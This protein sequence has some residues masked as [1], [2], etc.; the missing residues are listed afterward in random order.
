MAEVYKNGARG[1]LNAGIAAGDL[2]LTLRS[3]QGVLFPAWAGV[4]YSWGLLEQG[5][6]SN[7]TKREFVQFTNRSTDLLT[8]VRAQQGSSALAFDKGAR[9]SLPLTAQTRSDLLQSLGF[10]RRL[11]VGAIQPE[12]AATGDG[13]G[14]ISSAF[15]ASAFTRPTPSLGGGV[16]P[17]MP[18]LVGARFVANTATPAQ[19]ILGTAGAAP[20]KGGMEF[21][22]RGPL[23]ED[24]SATRKVIGVSN[25]SS[26][27]LISTV[28]PST[29]SS[30]AMVAFG[31]DDTIAIGGNWQVFTCDGTTMVVA[32]TGIAKVVGHLYQIRIMS[33]RGVAK[34]YA[35]L[36]D[37]TAGTRYFN[38]FTSNVPVIGTGMLP[39]LHAFRTSAPFS[40][41]ITWMG[42]FLF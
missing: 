7:P 26:T 40:F 11:P 1:R 24:N 12:G 16:G 8:M 34:W 4:D 29:L 42:N 9:V 36:I 39:T 17:S 41:T 32:S 37:M 23:E 20:D 30:V 10:N 15:N 25:S 2:T 31:Y 6:A 19:N 33:P 21:L 3:A 5:P 22:H 14:S 28:N 13:Y 38:G 27:T 35:E 18:R